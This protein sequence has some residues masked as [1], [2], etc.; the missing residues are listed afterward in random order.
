M[1]QNKAQKCMPTTVVKSEMAYDK[2]IKKKRIFK[3][4]MENDFLGKNQ[5]LSK[6]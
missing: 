3:L 2:S 4:K 1:G 5:F 6:M